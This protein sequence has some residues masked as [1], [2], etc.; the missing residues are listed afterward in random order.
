MNA[1]HWL[2]LVGGTSLL[3]V[4][5]SDAPRTN[6]VARQLLLA[7]AALVVLTPFAW[8]VCAAFK[9][10]ATIMAHAFL[11]PVADWDQGVFS[12]EN[13][14]QL[15]VP[16]PTLQGPVAFQ[17]Y[18][19]NSLFVAS[20]ATVI[21]LFFCSLGGYALAKIN[22]TGRR[23][24]QLFM[25]GTMTVPHLLFLAPLY[26]LV[27]MT[28]FADSYLALL[29]PG[30]ANAFGIFLFR[31]AMIRVPDSL[32]EAARI[33]GASDFAIYLRV[34]MPLVRPM[35]AAFCLIVFVGQWN[36]FVGPQIYLHSGYKLTLPVMLNQYVS[37]YA[38]DYGLFLAGTLLAILPV[39]LLFLALQ[40]EFIPGLTSGAVRE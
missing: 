19:I 17:Q 33:D 9:P 38:E 25:L 8:L 16:R 28:G 35:T 10:A 30:A 18:L 1:L 2:L 32:I 39:T 3:A 31:Q 5:W 26:R 21:Q 7:V 40:R 23:P 24:L 13:F 15:L 4:A 27:V 29:V 6:R 34:V 12:L 20:A 36:A 11:P 14:R 37:Q 22:F